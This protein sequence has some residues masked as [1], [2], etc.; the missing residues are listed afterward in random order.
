MNLSLREVLDAVRDENQPGAM[1][2]V[3]GTQYLFRT[4]GYHWLGKVAAITGKF[5][6]IDEATWVA[7]TGRFSDALNG[8]IEKLSS[9][10][11][12]PSPRPVVINSD[13]IT[14]AVEYPFS[15]PRGVK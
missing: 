3:V 14:D 15:I 2:F 9:A 12:E 8:G 10:E 7:N 4:I 5:L 6:T 13:H 1:P 11:L